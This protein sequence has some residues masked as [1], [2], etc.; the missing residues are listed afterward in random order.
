MHH[1][2]NILQLHARSLAR[3]RRS[4]KAIF[5]PTTSL[6]YRDMQVSHLLCATCMGVS[7][8]AFSATCDAP[9]A[10]RAWTI[11][12]CPASD[13]CVPATRSGVRE[14]QQVQQHAQSE[15]TPPR[16]LLATAL[17][18]TSPRGSGEPTQAEARQP[19]L[20]VPT[21]GAHQ[22]ERSRPVVGRLISRVSEGEQGSDHTGVP[23]LGGEVQRREPRPARLV[24]LR[25]GLCQWGH[26]CRVA[27]LRSEMERCVPGLV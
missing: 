19:S 15:T 22:V 23:V 21:S 5:A 10:R 8:L 20:L 3:R 9:A 13:A 18:T 16:S 26:N 6:I 25:P 27:F 17:A 12:A 1:C 7:P 11:S 2:L 24:H 14:T 4:S